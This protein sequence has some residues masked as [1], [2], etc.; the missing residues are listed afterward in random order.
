MIFDRAATKHASI[1]KIA[2]CAGASTLALAAATLPA[3]HAAA[4]QAP[5]QK[6]KI[7]EVVV[8]AEKRS[9]S[10]QKTPISITAITGKELQAAGITN[11]LNLA[12]QVP[13]I[14]F[15]TGGPGQT[16]LE[17]RGLNSAGGNSPTVGFY[18]DE[19]P[20]T[21]FAY[22]TSGKVVIDPDL[23]DLNRVEVLRGPQG[24]LYGGGSMGGTIRLITNQPVL[25]TYQ[26]SLE[27]IGSG[28][29]GGGPNGGFNLMANLPLVQDKAALRIVATDMYQSGW[30]D[31]IVLDP[32]PLPNN[33]G[34][35]R[36]DV[37]SAPVSSQKD[38]VNWEHL[39][40]AR[41][42]LLVQPNE[43]LTIT[44]MGMFQTINSGGQSLVDVPPATEAH[45]EPFNDPEPIRDQFWLASLNIKY[46]LGWAQL[47]STTAH[48]HHFLSQVQDGS[49]VLQ[50]VLALPGYSVADGGIGNDPWTENDSASQTSEEIRLASTGDGRFQWLAGFFYDDVASTTEQY[51]VD[52]DA[53]PALGI[54]TLFHELVAQTF[55]QKAV[56]GEASYQI[57]PTV[58]FTA[59]L[60]YYDFD[61]TFNTTEYGFFGP[62]G[63]L[64]PGSSV[65][66]EHDQGINP[67]FN[68]SF[69]P[70]PNLTLYATA[71]KGFRPGG[72]NEI[73]PTT[74]T[75]EGQACAA[76]LA[77][78]GK[79]SNPAGYAP[80]SLWNYELGEK[81]RF[82]DGRVTVNSAVYYE[83]WSQI[84]RN[85]TLSC[86]YIYTDNAGRANIYGGEVEVNGRVTNELTLNA[87]FAYTDATYAAN[88]LEAGVTKGQV[89]P[90]VPRVTTSQSVIWR[91]DL[92]DTYTLVARATNSYIDSRQ[93]VTYYIDTLPSYDTVGG[94]VGL[95]SKKGWTAYFFI[96]NA[97][98]SHALLSAI[99]SQVLNVP[100]LTRD[101]T[102]RPRT[103]GI[104][105]VA[106]F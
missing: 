103:F 19:T 76:S 69:T 53:V 66:N 75:E 85:V 32:F 15:K 95:T 4:Q 87:N 34:L 55:E 46:D 7:E 42:S 16:E 62:Y 100:T 104:D 93:D 79:T 5:D 25:N 21:T 30:I 48:W 90:D 57:L 96:D 11:V 6:T 47:V 72:G 24:T 40:S 71:A 102:L 58:K 9:A 86:G 56:F 91:H 105:L 38:G 43:N 81:A 84:Q 88:S 98:N 50:D 18:V 80:D 65:T 99:N 39:Q 27:A 63:T 94:R 14:S 83:D 60:R 28:T 35:T 23:Y 52:P 20:I 36:G 92:S 12:E 54:A 10:V 61:N 97:N 29:Q 64:Q 26:G 31:R 77:A 41:A 33:G 8:T 70:D 89:L 82:F 67:K 22:A 73:V 101:S 59:G 37:T 17:M 106:N 2:L 3:K 44:P 1:R 78:L 74:G 49:E 68:L 13:G 51:S 45:Y